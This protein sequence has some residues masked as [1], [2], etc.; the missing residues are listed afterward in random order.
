MT[1]AFEL[2]VEKFL[3]DDLTPA[4]LNLFLRLVK[5]PSNL[6]ILRR[7][8]TEKL[9]NREYTG[10]SDDSTIDLMFS[11]MLARAPDPPSPSKR[12][13]PVWRVAAAAAVLLVLGVGGF[14]LLNRSGKHPVAQKHHLPC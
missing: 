1:P 13:F 10:L 12:H 9:E 6:Q 8:V 4:E 14:L 2:L 11:Q 7:I 5:D 3:Q